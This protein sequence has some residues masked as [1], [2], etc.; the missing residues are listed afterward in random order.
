M[1]RLERNV[2]NIQDVR[3]DGRAVS[4]EEQN[5]VDN[6]KKQIRQ[7]SIT[8]DTFDF[9]E[10]ES[11]QDAWYKSQYSFDTNIVNHFGINIVSPLPD[12]INLAISECGGL[13]K[14]AKSASSS[15]KQSSIKASSIE[16]KLLESAINELLYHNAKT[17]IVDIF[18]R[19]T[20][21]KN[22]DGKIESKDNIT[23]E[24]HSIVLHKN[25]QLTNPL[26]FNL[27]TEILVID[28]S[29]FKSSNH[30]FSFFSELNDDIQARC[31]IITLGPIDYKIYKPLSNEVGP[32]SSDFRDCTDVSIK[33]AL[34]LNQSEYI[35]DT[36]T[37]TA[38]KES[39]NNCIITRYISNQEGFDK[40]VNISS[41]LSARIKQASNSETATS[42]NKLARLL[43]NQ[44]EFI[45]SEIN[46]PDEKDRYLIDQKNSFSEILNAS[47]P[48]TYEEQLNRLSLLNNSYRE[49]IDEYTP[50]IGNSSSDCCLIM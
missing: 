4:T 21:G 41:N 17:V 48:L 1:L 32:K 26:T 13:I 35:F 40:S 8:F 50:I 23:P 44:S 27:E 25:Q 24:V 37:P 22:N 11:W 38:L 3:P 12:D 7:R 39:I 10:L 16:K 14:G 18:H 33:I 15:S 6:V 46:N 9:I 36:S 19:D 28:P 31:K 42:Y 43:Y 47:S 29:N 20:F 34:G 49:T 45:A 2:N 30:L 5:V